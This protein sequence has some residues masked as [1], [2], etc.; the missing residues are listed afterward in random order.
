MVKGEGCERSASRER[1][2]HCGQGH[3]RVSGVGVECVEGDGA[4][5]G[6]RVLRS[7]LVG[8]K[9]R[10]VERD[11]SEDGLYVLLILRT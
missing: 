6:T 8:W 3:N 9:M 10:E 2:L 7:R 11:R 4:K 1:S 5:L